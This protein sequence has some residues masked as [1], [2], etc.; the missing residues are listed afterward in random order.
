VLA[1]P[2]RR[3]DGLFLSAGPAYVLILGTGKINLTRFIN[4]ISYFLFAV[5]FLTSG[6]CFGQPIS[7]LEIFEKKISEQ[8]DEIFYKPDIRR[9][10]QFIFVIK[11][12][13]N[14][15]QEVKFLTTVIKR[16]AERNKIRANFSNEAASNDSVFTSF[17][18]TV[19]ELNTKYNGFNKNKFLG[20]KTIKRNISGR[21]NVE[22]A[23]GNYPYNETD[24]INISYHDEV[25]YD[26]L[27][28]IESPDY[29]FTQAA[30]PKVSVWE[31]TVFPAV[32]IAVSIAAAVL[33]FTIRS[34]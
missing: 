10:V 2:R 16:A 21:V 11:S 19:A 20:T 5:I 1:P 30:A 24:T 13:K 22:A 6:I 26:M 29:K 9:D 3:C 17:W 18:I 28:N 31:E 4:I 14:D 23:G 32:L 34:K 8:L 15:R 25:A 7:N 27:E 33:F 12:L